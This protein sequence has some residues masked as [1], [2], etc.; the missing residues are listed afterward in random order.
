MTEFEVELKRGNWTARVRGSRDEVRGTA[1]SLP[2]ILDEIDDKPVPERPRDI[3]RNADPLPLVAENASR[4]TL[5]EAVLVTFLAYENK[6][7]T[8]GDLA[9][10]LKQVGKAF[11]EITL[12]R[13]TVPV[14]CREGFLHF[15]EVKMEG[16]RGHPPRAYFLTE[17]GKIEAERII[18]GLANTRQ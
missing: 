18:S 17:R 15:N 14:M 3:D 2:I 1:A 8:K 5:P 13:K 11:S 6:P 12:E 16:S 10:R 9:E 7:L 4:I